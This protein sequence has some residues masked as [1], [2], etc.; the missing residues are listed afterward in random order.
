M[1]PLHFGPFI[2]SLCHLV[3]GNMVRSGHFGGVS[4][5][6]YIYCPQLGAM[7][8]R[9]GKVS[10]KTR[11]QTLEDLYVEQKGVWEYVREMRSVE[12]L[13]GETTIRSDT[14]ETFQKGKFGYCEVGMILIEGRM[15]QTFED[16][17]IV[18]N[19]KYRYE[20]H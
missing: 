10:R 16:F 11:A 9:H 5:G 6:K 17:R 4:E 8:L 7:H 15:E 13:A 20:K 1:Q 14:L 2:F 12:L 3:E 18:S 19:G